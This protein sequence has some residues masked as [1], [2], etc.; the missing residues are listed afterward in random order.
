MNEEKALFMNP[1]ECVELK[2]NKLV[3]RPMGNTDFLLWKEGIY[4]FDDVP[5]ED[6]I[7]KFELYYDIVITVNNSKLMKYKF[8]GKFGRGMGWKVHSAHCGKSIILL[9]LKM[10]KNNNIVIR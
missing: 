7:K 2:D 8:S 6:I 1:N 5:F 4:A 10:K 9:I 3:K